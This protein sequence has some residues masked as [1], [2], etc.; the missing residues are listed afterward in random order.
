MPDSPDSML[1]EFSRLTGRI[2]CLEHALGDVGERLVKLG[3]GLSASPVA[4]HATRDKRFQLDSTDYLAVR[5]VESAL[6]QLEELVAAR[7]KAETLRRTLEQT[8]HAHLV[9]QNRR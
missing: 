7:K 3:Q 2:A 1:A 6:R 9:G 5:D 8:E 4:V